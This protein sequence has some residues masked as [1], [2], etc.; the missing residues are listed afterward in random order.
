M[1]SYVLKAIWLKSIPLYYLFAFL[2][3]LLCFFM[4]K[5]NILNVYTIISIINSKHTYWALTRYWTNRFSSS[6]KLLKTT[7][8]MRL[9][10]YEVVKQNI[11]VT[12]VGK[13][14]FVCLLFFCFFLPF[15]NQRIF[16]GKYE[17]YLHAAIYFPP[18]GLTN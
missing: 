3:F 16:S 4:L 11:F 8:Y 1:F 13:E 5:I 10:T 7:A 17:I 15:S 2:T 18:S 6:L 12:R 14:V 9:K